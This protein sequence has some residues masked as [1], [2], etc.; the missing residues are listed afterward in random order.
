MK[1]FIDTADLGEIQEAAAMGILDGVTTNPSLA[2]KAGARDFREH[3]LKICDLVDG[4]VSTEVVAPDYETMV[5]EGRA[6][7][8]L[9]DNI[10]VK[11][12][13]TL[14]GVKAINTFTAEGIRT[15][16]TLCFQPV[17]CLVA[18][19]AGAAYVS[20][21]IGRLDDISTNGMA[22]IR[23]V[24][25]IFDNYGLDTEVL[26]ASVRHPMHVV[27]AAEIGGDVV[28]MPFGVIEKLVKH[29]L[30]D[31]GLERFTAD[32]EAYQEETGTPSLLEA[33]AGNGTTA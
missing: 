16:C 27:E 33:V 13:M 32:W 3:I 18:A 15:N 23:S 5:E 25:T 4:D 17:Q 29:P 19:K 11:V 20:P 22:L 10:V 26:V 7:A 21:F 9:H 8:A 12:P 30:T 6:L 2:R 28:T 31:V 14:D 1:F 24:V